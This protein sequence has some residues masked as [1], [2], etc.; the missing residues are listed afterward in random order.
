MSN[1]HG[2]SPE[3]QKIADMIAGLAYR[4]PPHD[5]GARIMARIAPRPP[6]WPR[7]PAA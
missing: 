3:D 4:T 5:L 7:P 1:P 2:L 6:L